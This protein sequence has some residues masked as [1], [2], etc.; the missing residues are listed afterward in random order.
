M[1]YSGPVSVPQPPLTEDAQVA[2]KPGPS[3]RSRLLF[4]GAAAAAGIGAGVLIA[5]LRAP[6]QT[7]APVAPVAPAQAIVTW[8]AGAK[9]AP[10]F[11]LAD[12]NGQ[13]VSLA[14]FRGRPVI[15][16]FM[17]PVC[18]DFCPLEAK[19]V[20]RVLAQ[21]PAATRPAVVS[22]SVNLWANSHRILAG[23]Q[24]KW[25]LTGDWHW[26]IGAAPAL[27]KVWADYAIAVQDSPTTKNGKTTHEIA[28]TEA[29]FLVDA[30]GDQRAIFLWPFRAPD[31]TRTL[32]QISG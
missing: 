13:P 29:A 9:P 17:D 24:K 14:A 23:D 5:L 20:N 30:H 16:T 7:A 3:R 25:K 11:S 28:H 10:D 18:T 19:V 21:F 12:E 31:V 6:H 1:Q 26:A 4:W 22:V 15:V 2:P 27:R 8:K 32:R